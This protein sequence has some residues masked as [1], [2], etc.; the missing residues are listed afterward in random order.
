ME[1]LGRTENQDFPEGN[2]REAERP[3]RELLPLADQ[4]QVSEIP[5]L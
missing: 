3:D 4:V 1:D 5:G 2:R